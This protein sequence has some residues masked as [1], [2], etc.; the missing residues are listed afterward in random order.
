MVDLLVGV[1]ILW[2]GVESSRTSNFVLKKLHHALLSFYCGVGLE[3]L[4]CI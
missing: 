1:S 3:R 2:H 4:D